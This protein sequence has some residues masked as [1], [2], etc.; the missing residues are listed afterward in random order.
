M[1]VTTQ[2]AFQALF[3]SRVETSCGP[4]GGKALGEGQEAPATT[5]P[6]P[7]SGEV[8]HAQA[9][10]TATGASKLVVKRPGLL[11]PA[12]WEPDLLLSRPEESVAQ[13]YR[14][15][16]LL[17]RG[18]K[19]GHTRALQHVRFEQSSDSSIGSSRS[20]GSGAYV[21]YWFR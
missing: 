18:S 8:L 17:K 7:R 10:P 9:R 21:A 3:G 14:I 12:L 20:L 13:V 15:C 1:P 16:S 5:V 11:M 4:Y 2:R 19:T 6:S